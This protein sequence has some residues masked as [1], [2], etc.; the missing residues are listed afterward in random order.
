MIEIDPLA[1]YEA[2][3]YIADSAGHSETGSC[4]SMSL[5]YSSSS[6]SH[7]MHAERSSH[8]QL[9]T[10]KHTPQPTRTFTNFNNLPPELKLLICKHTVTHAEPLDLSKQANQKPPTITRVSRFFQVEGTKIYYSHNTFLMPLSSDLCREERHNLNEWLR[11]DG[12]ADV[13]RKMR[14]IL[15]EV[16]LPPNR[17]SLMNL[18]ELGMHFQHLGSREARQIVEL[19]LIPVALDTEGVTVPQSLG[20][21]DQR[22]ADA[23]WKVFD[24]DL[25]HLGQGTY[26]VQ[27]VDEEEMEFNSGVPLLERAVALGRICDGLWSVIVDIWREDDGA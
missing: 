27:W 7:A 14:K 21:L 16:A 10:N 15:I 24:E 6:K 12:T 18:L 3:V 8:N 2:M 22:I 5:P 19:R 26:R 25:W 17:A 9:G 20:E 23:F 13:C 1:R 11:S 4:S